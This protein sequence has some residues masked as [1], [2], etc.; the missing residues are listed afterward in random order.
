M[1]NQNRRRCDRC[2]RFAPMTNDD[3]LYTLPHEWGEPLADQGAFCERCISR[4]DQA[5]WLVWW[6]AQ[7]MSESAP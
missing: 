3:G 2:G 1:R 6:A 5:N 4:F 7:V